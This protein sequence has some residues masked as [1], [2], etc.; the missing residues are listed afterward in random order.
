MAEKEDDWSS[1]SNH[2][3]QISLVIP[4]VGAAKHIH[5]FHPKMSYSVFGDDERIFGYKGLKIHLRYNSSDMR[6]NVLVSYEKKFKAVGDTEATDVKELLEPYLPKL[7]WE[8]ASLFEKQIGYPA[9]ND[10]TPPGE[11]IKTFTQG[12]KTLEIWKGDLSDPGVRQMVK[13][14]QILIPLF[15]EGGSVIDLEDS[16]WSLQRWTVFFL[17]QKAETK[18]PGQSPYTFMGYSTV[19]RFYYFQPD[20]P[21]KDKIVDFHLPLNS[22]SLASQPCRSR[23]SQFIILPPFQGGGNGSR[24]YNSIFD[25]FLAEPETVEIT[26]EDPNYAFDDMRDLNDLARLRALPEFEAIKINT[27]VVPDPKGNIPNNIVD[28]AAL[29]KIRKSVKIAPRQ[30]L[31]VVEM[32]L[33]SRIPTSVRRS[34]LDAGSEKKIPAIDEP[35]V[36]DYN[37]WLLWLTKRLWKHNRD[38]FVQMEKE[39]RLEALDGVV[40]SVL[41]DYARLLEL[42]EARAEKTGD[43][44]IKAA[45]EAG[46][47]P[48]MSVKEQAS[49]AKSYGKRANL[50]DEG[51]SS[52]KKVKALDG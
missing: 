22:I 1:D 50:S 45:D 25:Y 17:Y 4:D 28:E 51:E 33:L 39:Q 19:Y 2:A 29:E 10:W 42:Y 26:V 14:I 8:K 24:F 49:N 13:R 7:A 36:Q 6:P 48:V 35:W 27:E 5:T 9:E 15:I 41:G 43:A 3:L 11:L 40:C 34:T 52:S 47:K 16:D 30:F 12:N 44:S 18:V 46:V 32:H 31:R 21:A 20:K 38:S 23:I 37:L